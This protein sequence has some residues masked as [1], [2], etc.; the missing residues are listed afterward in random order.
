MVAYISLYGIYKGFTY[1]V[2]VLDGHSLEGEEGAERA[3]PTLSLPSM[4]E[5]G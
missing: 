1:Y 5:N 2:V 4:R 3:Q